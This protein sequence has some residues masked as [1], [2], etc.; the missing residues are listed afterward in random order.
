MRRIDLPSPE[1]IRKMVRFAGDPVPPKKPVFPVLPVE[2]PVVVERKSHPSKGQPKRPTLPPEEATRMRKMRW[3]GML[4]KDIAIKTGWSIT[5]VRNACV[6][7]SM[8]RKSG[9]SAKGERVRQLFEAGATQYEIA[10][11]TGTSRPAVR[12]LLRQLGLAK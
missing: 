7:V 11:M 4:L 10:K 8:L 6:G 1:Y 9:L 12:H 2:K 5:C 3:E